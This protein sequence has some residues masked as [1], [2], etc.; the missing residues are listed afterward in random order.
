[1]GFDTPAEAAQITPVS[2]PSKQTTDTQTTGAQTTDKP[3][4]ETVTIFGDSEEMSQQTG[5]ITVDGNVKMYYQD[6]LGIGPRAIIVR[7]SDGRPQKVY[8]VGRSQILQ[9]GKRWIADHI[10][11][12][13]P[14]GE[15][16]CRQAMA[17]QSSSNRRPAPN[18]TPPPSNTSPVSTNG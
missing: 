12:T 7:D 16:S 6:T 2:Q 11:L 17:R 1:M 13:V 8:F 15:R 9:P 3:K 14:D 4:D 5:R 10:T 18:S